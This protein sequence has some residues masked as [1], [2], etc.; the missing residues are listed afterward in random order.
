MLSC[1]RLGLLFKASVHGYTGPVFHQKCDRQGPTLTVAYNNSGY[2]FGA[3]TSKDY[4][5]T[6]QNIE[7]EKAFLFSFSEREMKK[8]PLRVVSGQPQYSFYDGAAGPH[9]NSLVF[10]NNNTA[11]VYSNP[12]TYVFDP[13]E[14]HGNDLQLVECEVYRVEGKT[15]TLSE[16]WLF[17]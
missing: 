15:Q 12:G 2:I 10:L 14:M 11:T 17:L 3:Y 5:Q 13:L 9:F 16:K 6:G 1:S 4:A 8:D 7:D